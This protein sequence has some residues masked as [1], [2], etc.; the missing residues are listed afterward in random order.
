[1][2]TALHRRMLSSSFVVDG[3]GWKTLDIA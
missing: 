1:M 2:T 3:G